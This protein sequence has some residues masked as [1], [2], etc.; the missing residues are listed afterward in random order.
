MTEE[1]YLKSPIIRDFT[2]WISEKLSSTYNHNYSINTNGPA[3]NAWVAYNNGPDWNC[4]T[5]YNAFQKYH[6]GKRYCDFN[7]N[8]AIL[9]TLKDLGISGLEKRSSDVISAFSLLVFKWGGVQG[10]NDYIINYPPDTGF[11]N[12]FDEIS[13][14][15][16]HL[17]PSR[18]NDVFPNSRIKL[19]AGFTKIYSLLIDDFIIYDS[20]VARALCK[21]VSDF[22]AFRNLAD[23]NYID[24]LLAFK[25]PR[26]RSDVG[27]NLIINNRFSFQLFSNNNSYHQISNLRA[28]WILKE[29]LRISHSSLFNSIPPEQRLRALEA[30]LFMIGY[31]IG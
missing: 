4:N 31:R 16:T 10:N 19:N 1:E 24:S 28:S 6:W 11:A 9:D 2:Q 23:N 14:G 15:I 21:M 29:A 30:S 25:I 13:N 18:F 3:N 5:I 12:L 26:G 22:L 7:S 8:S 17:N 27:G 20:R